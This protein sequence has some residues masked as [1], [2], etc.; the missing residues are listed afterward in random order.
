[1]DKDDTYLYSIYY[2]YYYL[3]ATYYYLVLTFF[4]RQQNIKFS[5]LLLFAKDYIYIYDKIF[6]EKILFE[7]QRKKIS[8]TLEFMTT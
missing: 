6:E 8:K 4:A 2:Y 7:N 1:M 3:P 5:I